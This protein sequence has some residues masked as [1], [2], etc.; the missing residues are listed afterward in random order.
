VVSVK[1][2]DDWIDRFAR[3]GY[4]AKGV[5]YVLIGVLALTARSAD[6]RNAIELINAE[7]LGKLALLVVVL[8]LLRTSAGVGYFFGYRKV[9][10]SG[11]Q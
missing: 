10:P 8:G 11:G 4:V 7:P 5:V 1:R 6:R 3:L 2:V 9:Y